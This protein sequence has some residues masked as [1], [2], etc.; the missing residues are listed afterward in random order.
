MENYYDDK[1]EE[2]NA[3]N[4]AVY[5]SFMISKYISFICIKF[6]SDSKELHLVVTCIT[7]QHNL[8]FNTIV[9]GFVYPLLKEVGITFTNAPQEYVRQPER[10]NLMLYVFH[11][12][13]VLPLSSAY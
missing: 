1:T 8:A 10:N 5:K 9:G 7:H 3:S 12:I 4:Q 11:L 13:H 2:L 6:Q